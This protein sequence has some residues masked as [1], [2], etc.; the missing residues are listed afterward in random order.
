MYTCCQEER[1]EN[2]INVVVDDVFSPRSPEMLNK[3]QT[4]TYVG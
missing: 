1:L 3:S 4:G 2:E